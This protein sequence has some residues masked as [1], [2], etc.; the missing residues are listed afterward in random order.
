MHREI[1]SRNNCLI[2]Y[3]SLY[4]INVQILF[5]VR[6]FH[7]QFLFLHHMSSKVDTH[8]LFS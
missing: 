6:C 4:H 3:I 5:T 8:A 7:P 2:K 1:D